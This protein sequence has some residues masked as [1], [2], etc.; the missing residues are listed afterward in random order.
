MPVTPPQRGDRGHD[1]M[2]ESSFRLTFSSTNL[3]PRVAIPLRL[4]RRGPTV[5]LQ[6]LQNRHRA[7]MRC[8]AVLGHRPR[9]LPAQTPRLVPF[10]SAS[11][12]TVRAV[13]R[14]R[15]FASSERIL[16]L[17]RAS[18]S[19]LHPTALT[20]QDVTSTALEFSPFIVASPWLVIHEIRGSLLNHFNS[21][22][23]LRLRGAALSAVSP[24]SG[25]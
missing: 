21:G 4:S 7:A 25:C 2:T 24:R 15:P 16:Q 20:C 11:L 17:R 13:I 5:A 22:L 12:H 14:Y 8:R 23:T 18:A 1:L 10:V 3:R 9:A 6:L 19:G